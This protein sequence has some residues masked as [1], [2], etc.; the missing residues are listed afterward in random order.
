MDE[1]KIIED[2]LNRYFKAVGE[3]DVDTLKTIFHE[4]AAMYGYLGE[5]TVLA[6]PQVFYDDLQSKPSMKESGTDCRC[7]IVDITVTG[8]VAAASI[9]VT[10]FYGMCDVT[11]MFHLMKLDGTWRI[12]CKSFT[13]C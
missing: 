12:V 3:A 9:Y 4:K 11:D 6:T 5:D 10:N 1:R 7:K 13:T 8:N 2:L